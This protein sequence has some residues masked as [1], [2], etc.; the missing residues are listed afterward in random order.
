MQKMRSD[1][2]TACRASIRAVPFPNGNANIERDMFITFEGIDSSGKTTQLLL[3]EA[4]LRGKA[5]PTL[6]IRE[7]GGTGLSE[8]IRALLLDPSHGEMDEIAEL[9]LFSAARAQLARDAIIPALRQGV[10]VI[11]DRFS[12]STTAYQGYGR[13]IDL[14]AIERINALA[15]RGVRPDLTF[16]LDIPWEESVRRRGLALRTDDRMERASK[17][18]FDRVRAGYRAICDAEA[19]R[20]VVIDGAADPQAIHA[21]IAGRVERTL[22]ATTAIQD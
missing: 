7:P 17:E 14:A 16:F 2:G 18:F 8:K 20:C 9:F 19:D 10:T 6:V 11:S 4:R 21:E 13:G 1:A 12:D 3:L 5:L 15:A 22:H